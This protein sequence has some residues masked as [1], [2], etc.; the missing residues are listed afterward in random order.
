MKR[1]LQEASVIGR[2]FLYQILKRITDRS[3]QCDQCLSGLERLD[4]IRARSLQ[5]DLEY[6]FK[7]AL[8]QEV[9][10]NGLLKKERRILH[11][12][13]GLVVEQLFHNRL[14]EFYETLAF[15]FKNG[16]SLLKA[17][18]YLMKSGEK[19]MKRYAVEESHQYYKEAFDLLT[20][21]PGKTREEERLLIDLVIE[22]ADVLYYIGDFKELDKLL[23]T[24][25]DL[26]ES[27][28]DKARLGMFYAWVGW[29]V[30]WGDKWR[31]SYEYLHKALK[32]GE[33]IEN[34]QVIGYACTWLSW[35][36]AELGFLDEAILH[37][38]RAQEISKILES[39]QYLYFKS[40]GGL[41]HAYWYRGDKKKG[42]ETGR[43]NVE[44]GHRH[45]N[46][47][48]V[49]MGHNV[50][51]YSAFVDGDLQEVIECGQRAAQAALD[52]F[53]AQFPKMLLSF[54]YAL[55]GQFQEAEDVSQELV[56]YC[57]DFGNEWIA[58]FPKLVLGVVSIAKGHMSEGLKMLEDIR[59]A[60]LENGRRSFYAAIEHTLGSVYLQMAQGEG[61]ISPA[62]EKA[63]DHFNKAIEVAKE[64]GAKCTLGMA[65]L[66]LG[67]LHKAKDQ[68]D[69]AIRWLSKAIEVFEECEAET[70]LKHAREALESLG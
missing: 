27:L 41:G 4:L 64:I 46:I 22:W 12:K 69:Q 62:A 37:G 68:K 1:V 20:N 21:K 5:P 6:I 54:G 30:C 26:A 52:P 51:G 38:E 24:H 44:F 63:E 49:V 70:R 34:Q 42:Y 31:E 36:C 59:Q 17:V 39:D 28:D 9:V 55:T 33:E 66:D 32:L 2:A 19:S 65:Y 56:N 35:S 23:S 3:D 10:Y 67:L 15:H 57:R 13:I 58:S 50:M 7:H 29:A 16:H 18:D 45:S 25:K 53:Y 40:M 43:A 47:R 8:T 48:S 61:Q 60:C 14:S 11:E